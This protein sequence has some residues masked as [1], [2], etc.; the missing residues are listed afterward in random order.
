MK[1][2]ALLF[3]ILM[4]YYCAIPSTTHAGE[5]SIRGW[6]GTIWLHD[7]TKD[8]D[9]KYDTGFAYGAVYGTTWFC[10]LKTE[11]E[12]FYSHNKINDIKVDSKRMRI[13]GSTDNYAALINI[14][15]EFPIK[16]RK[17]QFSPYLGGGIGASYEK[18]QLHVGSLPVQNETKSRFACQYF[19]GIS[20]PILPFFLGEISANLEGRYCVFDEHVR[21]IL[22]IGGI[23]VRF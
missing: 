12:V 6:A 10:Y 2:K 22:A 18:S 11:V 7:T 8:Y 5:S 20:F 23:A 13:H 9:V 1:Q 14:A 4:V 17:I 16:L 3:A 21:S 19:G 15:V